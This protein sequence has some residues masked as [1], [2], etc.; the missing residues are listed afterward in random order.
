MSS[1]AKVGIFM[2][3]ILAILGFFILRIEDIQFGREAQ[4]QEINAIFDDVAGLD[5][6]SAVR[7]AG[8]RVGTVKTIHPPTPDGKAL[9]TLEVSKEIQLRQGAQAKVT[10]MGLLGEK[11]VE[12][13]TGPPGAAVIA[14]T[15]QTP[16]PGSATAS[17]D[18]VT[19]QVSLIASDLKAITASLRN[20]MGG[21][22]GEQRVE[23]IVTNV[24]AITGRLRYLIEANEGNVSATAAN[25]RALTAD[26]RV[27][28]P[29]IVQSIDRFTSTMTGTVGENREDARAVMQNLRTLS[30]DLKATADNLTDI[31]GQVKSGEGS[32]GKLIY[33]DEAHDR[34]T[35]ALGSVESGVAELR[36]TLGRV[37]RLALALDVRSEYYVGREE[38]DVGF[39]GNSRSTL[40]AFIVPNPERNR[41]LLAGVA[42]DPRGKKKEKITETTVIDASGVESTTVERQ[43]KYEREFLLTAQAGWRLEDFDIRLGL[44][45]ST[46]GVGADYRWN[47]RATI[48]GEA[49]DFGRRYDDNAHLRLFGT[50]IFRLEKEN[51]PAVF[52]TSG[53][54]D[55]L[56]DLAVTVGGGIRWSDDDL[57]YLLGSIPTP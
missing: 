41:F 23:A 43:T 11:Y 53:V 21:P 24:Q 16:L 17:I 13:E 25:L 34:L 36:N 27:E 6:K 9:V 51:F 1:A 10:S 15:T 26:L 42:D 33:S 56:N 12:L 30:T 14:D 48:T 4:T 38:Q 19:D 29:R 28:I 54:D 2:I 7:V 45:E 8:V 52:V 5:E 20:V 37:G 50:Y 47:N 57:K 46:G 22:E 40:N 31:T 44:I 39:G 3:A 35:S 18:H 49:F 55:V 32:V